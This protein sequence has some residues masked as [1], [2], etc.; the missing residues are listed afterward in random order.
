[1]ISPV[2]KIAPK[3]VELETDAE[4]RTRFRIRQLTGIERAAVFMER[5][6]KRRLR[7]VI[8]AGLLTVEGYDLGAGSAVDTLPDFA[9]IWLAGEI[10]AFSTVSE[11]AKKNSS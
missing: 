8:D 7:E 11:E 1:M 2:P 4:P 10:I 9:V 5:D 3:W 6:H